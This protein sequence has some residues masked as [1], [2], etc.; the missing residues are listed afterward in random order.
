M[1]TM[2]YR[3]MTSPLSE[4]N[5]HRGA[6]RERT[7]PE[8]SENELLLKMQKK[9]AGLDSKQMKVIREYEQ[10]LDAMKSEIK[11]ISTGYDGLRQKNS[12][13]RQQLKDKNE[14]LKK[15]QDE[16]SR[17]TRHSTSEVWTSEKARLLAKIKQ[18]EVEK[19]QADDECS[20]LSML[21]DENSHLK[22]ELESLKFR[23]TMWVQEKE[24]AEKERRRNKELGE[25]LKLAEKPY[26]DES[27]P[28]SMD[29]S[30][31]N[32][33]KNHSFNF[34][35]AWAQIS[36]SPD[37]PFS[38]LPSMHL[39]SGYRESDDLQDIRKSLNEAREELKLGKGETQSKKSE[40][41]KDLEERSRTTQHTTYDTKKEHKDTE[42]D[43]VKQMI[44]TLESKISSLE[45][46]CLTEVRHLVHNVDVLKKEL[47][48][49]QQELR[50]LKEYSRQMERRREEEKQQ[51]LNESR[52]LKLDLTS[53]RS[54]I[55]DKSQGSDRTDLSR[56]ASSDTREPER[57]QSEENFENHYSPLVGFVGS[58]CNY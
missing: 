23:E 29:W 16:H 22:R 54:E 46:N 44:K 31:V 2:M 21:K 8:L 15:L 58:R 11:K 35:E 1:S 12:R 27:L 7:W 33:N 28:K 3:E 4:R 51:M 47:H 37:L 30:M 52:E 5:G 39:V 26:Q 34:D 40:F 14:Q 24:R 49:S 53:L 36:Q 9:M 38:S 50:S 19:K 10:E 6:T 42:A 45:S 57:G 41:L 25:I 20:S 56:G 32:N 18:L 48:N 13:Y 43:Q 17:V 55:R